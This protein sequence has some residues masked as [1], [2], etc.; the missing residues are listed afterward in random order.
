MLS[1]ETMYESLFSI[2]QLCMNS[3]FVC[4]IK[5]MQWYWII[6]LV[7]DRSNKL[8]ETLVTN[9][10][11]SWVLWGG[12]LSLSSLHSSPT[13]S[14]FTRHHENMQILKM[15]GMVNLP[16]GMWYQHLTSQKFWEVFRRTVCVI[17][18]TYINAYQ[19]LCCLAILTVIHLVCFHN[20]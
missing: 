10:A 11:V 2:N 20:F 18:S 16:L 17:V 1:P 13:P 8:N 12:F 6:L 19:Q 7:W 9:D 4:L 5:T 14:D 3:N 15:N